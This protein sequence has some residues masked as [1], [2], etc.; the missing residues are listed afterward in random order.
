MGAQMLGGRAPMLEFYVGIYLVGVFVSSV[1]QVLLKKAASRE[2]HSAVREYL[3]PWV[4]TA[5]AMF[6]GA[7]LMTIFSYKVVPLSMGAIL[8]ATA[9]LY[10]TFFGVVIFKEKLSWKKIAALSLIV[11]GIII[12]SMGM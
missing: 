10:I 6:F 11:L 1:S 9:Y 7:T 12:Y 4:I 5:Y 2:Y 3:N 8:E